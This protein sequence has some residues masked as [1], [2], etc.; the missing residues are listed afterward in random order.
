M[1]SRARGGVR[2]AARDKDRAARSVVERREV[3]GARCAWTFVGRLAARVG[4]REALRHE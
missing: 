3:L 4:G 1:N 2:G